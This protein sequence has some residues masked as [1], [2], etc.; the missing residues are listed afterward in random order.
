MYMLSR[1]RFRL[2][3]AALLFADAQTPPSTVVVDV[4]SVVSVVTPGASTASG[5]GPSSSPASAVPTPGGEPVTPA[6]APLDFFDP[7]G[8]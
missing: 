6:A 4:G 1:H 7:R 8:C 5:A 3:G 2:A